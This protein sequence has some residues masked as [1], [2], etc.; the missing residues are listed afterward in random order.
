MLADHGLPF[1]LC[2]RHQQLR[3]ALAALSP[4]ERDAVL[5]RTASSVY[6]PHQWACGEHPIRR[7]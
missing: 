2:V 1:D 3:E 7:V 4:A 6:R 5:R